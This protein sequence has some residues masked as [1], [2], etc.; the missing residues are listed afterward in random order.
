MHDPKLR[1]RLARVHQPTLLLWGESDRV[2]T[3]AYGAAY[4]DAFAD[5][6]LTVIPGAGHLPQ[7]ERPKETFALIDDH[8]ARTGGT[9]MRP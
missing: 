6:R 4:A 1:H 3:P 8:L 2:V 7:L 5:G 9:G